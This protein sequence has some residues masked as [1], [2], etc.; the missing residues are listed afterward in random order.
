MRPIRGGDEQLKFYL[1]VK[2]KMFMSRFN[3]LLRRFWA[4][5]V[6]LLVLILYMGYVPDSP[7]KA[8][9]V[10]V[11][12]LMGWALFIWGIFKRATGVD[13]QPT[14]AHEGVR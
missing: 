14:I 2:Y 10:I 13:D 8:E 1:T 12:S 7:S 3:E 11:L 5:Y 4:G 6:V 9:G